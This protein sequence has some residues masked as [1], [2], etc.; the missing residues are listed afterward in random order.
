MK[1]YLLAEAS[2][3]DASQFS[4]NLDS[5]PVESA[6]LTNIKEAF[7][8]A[9]KGAALGLTEK[10]AER[11][12]SQLEDYSEY[13]K[14]EYEHKLQSELKESRDSLE[15]SIDSYLSHIAETWLQ[16]NR[17]AVRSGIKESMF[18]SLM[19]SMKT[20]FVEHNVSVPDEEV[21]VVSELEE[22]LTEANQMVADLIKTKESLTEESNKLKKSVIIAEMT[23]NLT[24][25][26][27][28]R[29]Q[30]LAEEIE[31]DGSFS[32]KLNTVVSMV[33]ATKPQEPKQKQI[34]E[35]FVPKSNINTNVNKQ[36]PRMAA[37]LAAA[38]KF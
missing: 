27:K 8:T 32:S 2:K 23:E 29:V 30:T 37:Y 35:S 36:T 7:E 34:K 6:Q 21:D 22:Q 31:F 17:I 1:E 26:Q 13:L 18:D 25:S 33:T 28:E 10:L 16:E 14:E 3:L 24:E 38:R 11:I 12:E 9:V 20:I 19:S 4:S 5:L 15:E